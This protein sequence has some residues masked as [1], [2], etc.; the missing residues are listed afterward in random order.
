[1]PMD[2]D[3]RMKSN[4]NARRPCVTD[5][6]QRLGRN[7]ESLVQSPDHIEREFAPAIPHFVHAMLKTARPSLRMLAPRIGSIGLMAVHSKSLSS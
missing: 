7:A 5:F 1:L 3:P 4:C 6:D 2:S